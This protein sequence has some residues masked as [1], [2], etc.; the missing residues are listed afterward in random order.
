[1]DD[2]IHLAANAAPSDPPP[3]MALPVAES[4]VPLT[5]ANLASPIEIRGK[6]V[7]GRLLE[8]PAL[9]KLAANPRWAVST[10]NKMPLV[11]REYCETGAVRGAS[12]HVEEDMCTLGEIAEMLPSAPNA[13]YYLNKALDACVMLDV[14]PKAS[15]E[16]KRSSLGLPWSYA[17]ASMSGQGL[18]LLIPLKDISQ[19]LD[20]Y[21]YAQR[22]VIKAKDASWELHLEHWVTFTGM[23]IDPMEV[24][25]YGETD[26]ADLIEDTLASLPPLCG[27]GIQ[28]HAVDNPS[29]SIPGFELYVSMGDAYMLPWPRTE[30]DYGLDRSSLDFATCVRTAGH[31][32]RQGVHE[33]LN[34]DELRCVIEES[35]RHWLESRGYDRPKLDEPRGELTYLGMTAQR[36]LE[37]VM[38]DDDQ[39]RR[40]RFR[41]PVDPDDGDSW[42][43]A[44]WM[45]CRLG[46]DDA[47]IT[48]CARLLE[49]E[50]GIDV[51]S[52]AEL[53]CSVPRSSA[54]EMPRSTRTQAA[55]AIAQGKPMPGTVRRAVARAMRKV[56]KAVVFDADV[57]L[58][59]ADSLVQAWAECD[60][61]A[62]HVAGDIAHARKAID[63]LLGDLGYDSI[64]GESS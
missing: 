19:L 61:T 15:A 34:T 63:D 23:A 48:D 17:E 6:G 8:T 40:A 55:R 12:C 53:A 26:L 32:V 46:L 21:P 38:S 14:E 28:H 47:R 13:A 43:L 10:P 30:T 54:I 1:M 18:H 11:V 24:E 57:A 44:Y 20:R 9:E 22:R 62:R 41:M 60:E 59:V 7:A 51:T 56:A 64:Y 5:C 25:G 27:F 16:L 33:S 49:D 37:V 2:I 42:A 39:A 3:D 52:A 36:A 45:R 31:L 35:A 50:Y 29:Q 4:P 58:E